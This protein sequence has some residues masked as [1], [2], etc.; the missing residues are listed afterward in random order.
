[1][2]RQL[3]A[4]AAAKEVTTWLLLLRD[5]RAHSE[6]TQLRLTASLDLQQLAAAYEAQPVEGAACWHGAE[7]SSWAGL[8]WQLCWRLEPGR[9]QKKRGL[10]L[11]VGVTFSVATP[12]AMKGTVLRLQV[13][14][15]RH[16][17]AVVPGGSVVTRGK[18]VAEGLG[19][20]K[21]LVVARQGAAVACR[22]VL[23]LQLSTGD[24][25]WGEA[26]QQQL[27]PFLGSSGKLELRVDIV[28]VQ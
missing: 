4:A 7:Y 2:E 12:Q 9:W 20:W 15:L 6:V 13:P 24:K 27:Q 25:H 3:K 21:Q 28:G 10:Q 8:E 17:K 11:Q 23:P 19:P 26:Q 18:A 1:L 5:P 16:A 22:E 14:V